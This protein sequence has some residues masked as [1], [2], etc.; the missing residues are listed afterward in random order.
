M[1]EWES[2]GNF[3]AGRVNHTAPTK[4]A[5]GPRCGQRG[6]FK[7]LASIST[8]TSPT[9]GKQHGGR[10]TIMDGFL[11]GVGLMLLA[12]ALAPFLIRLLGGRGHPQPRA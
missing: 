6:A 1:V 8:N 2:G 10:G 11:L 9:A 4:R 3:R 12:F 7:E 5:H